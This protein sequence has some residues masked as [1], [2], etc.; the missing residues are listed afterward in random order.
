MIRPLSL[1]DVNT[2]RK[3]YESDFSDGWSE[4]QLVSAFNTNRFIAIGSFFEDELVGVITLS[5]GYDD[6]DLE[7]IVVKQNFRRN[8]IALNLLEYAI[9]HIKEQKKQRILLEV[10]EGNTPAINFY[11]KSGFNTISV[12]KD[13]YP[14]GENAIVMV[15]EL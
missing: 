15:K 2:I 4:N 6:A 9:K 7:G 10:R 5:L 11:L 8:K 14:N 12:R 3:L 13:Y 1:T